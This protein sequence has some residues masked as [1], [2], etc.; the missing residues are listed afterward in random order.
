MQSTECRL[1]LGLG[2]GLGLVR[3]GVRV[4]VR[5]RIRVGDLQWIASSAYRYTINQ[6]Q[7]FR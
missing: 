4:K 3:V 1:G 5:V 2:L 6:F 7:N